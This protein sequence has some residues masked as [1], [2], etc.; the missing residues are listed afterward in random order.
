[1]R[2]L[3]III[4]ALLV[5]GNVFSQ[6]IEFFHGSFEEAKMKAKTENKPLFVDVFTSW[7]GPCKML[8]KK[9]F[10]QKL[11]GDY[12][13]QSFVSF[14]LQTDKEGSD[15]QKIADQYHVSAYPTLMWLDGDGE[16]L[17]LSIGY[18]EAEELVNE[19]KIV[20][21]KDKR[22][23]SCIS[24]W[25]KGDRSLPVAARYFLFD[26]NSKGEFDNYFKGLTEEQK[27]DS[28]T[29]EI[30]SNVRLDIDGDV[31]AFVVHHR[32]DY[33]KVAYGFQIDRAIDSR[34]EWELQQNYGTDKFEQVCEKYK[35]IGFEELGLFMK[36]AEWK[37]YLEKSDFV[38]FEKSA[39]EYVQ[40]FLKTHKYV[41]SE[42]VWALHG[43]GKEEFSKFTNPALVVEWANQVKKSMDEPGRFCY[44]ELFAQIIAGDNEKAKEIGNDYLKSI[45]GKTDYLST[46]DRDYIESILDEIK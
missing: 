12:F 10:P 35:R 27:L 15:N 20:F 28:L 30:I 11:V 8:S 26:K 24:K 4:V 38:S 9:V 25:N 6:G 21:D 37:S 17:H 45:E 1:M 29:F 44:A 46:S 32:K 2:R 18:K 19:A 13:N 36:R 22:V 7:C 34:I 43:V 14:K 40:E 31:F 39:K 41:C 33:Q 3:I 42:L 5:C 23:G 16:L